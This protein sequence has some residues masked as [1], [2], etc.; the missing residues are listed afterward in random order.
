MGAHVKPGLAEALPEPHF[1]DDVRFQRHTPPDIC[2]WL[3][4]YRRGVRSRRQQGRSEDGAECRPRGS[5]PYDGEDEQ[6]HGGERSGELK[7]HDDRR[8]HPARK[9]EGT[10]EG[11]RPSSNGTRH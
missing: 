4:L 11:R 9:K 2:Q 8:I 3:C 6:E 10:Q 7:A 5:A 1:P